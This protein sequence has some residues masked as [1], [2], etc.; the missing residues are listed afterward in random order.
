[1]K[2]Y[3]SQILSMA[4]I[5]ISLVS[6]CKVFGQKD[7]SFTDLYLTSLPKIKTADIIR[8]YRM[9]TI[10]INRDLYGKFV[11]KT[12]ITGECTRGNS[13][14]RLIWNNAIISHSDSFDGEFPAGTRQEYMENFSYLPSDDMLSAEA[15][16]SFPSNPDNILARNLIWD[17]MTFETYA[18]MFWDSLELNKPY[19]IKQINGEFNMAEIGTYDHNLITVCWKGITSIEGE[20]CAIID[21]TATDNLLNIS[22]EMMKS[23]GTEQYWGTTWVSLKTRNIEK[24]LMYG[25][26][27]QEI[28]ISGMPEK[29]LFKTIRE[30]WLEPIK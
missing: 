21:F 15:F 29:M 25:G 9:T 14:G 30:L 16:K 10:H 26:V 3:F 13:D 7:K 23:R 19:E 1:M 17:M 20:L 12:K 5:L 2:K 6:P 4:L 18:W 28:E 11:N 8:K 24:A 27:M 22:M